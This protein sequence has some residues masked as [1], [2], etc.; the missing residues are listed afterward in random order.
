MT[1]YRRVERWLE[2]GSG[3]R[4]G[5]R[6]RRVSTFAAALGL[7]P[8]PL[9]RAVAV[10]LVRGLAAAAQK[11]TLRAVDGASRAAAQLE[12]AGDLQWPVDN[13]VYDDWSIALLQRL[14]RLRRR[15]AGSGESGCGMAAVA[16]RFVVRCTASA[17]SG[18]HRAHACDLQIRS[19]GER[20]VLAH[21]L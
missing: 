6:P 13:W 3:V 21:A 1:L 14:G 11:T 12:I 8:D 10:R 15:L 17:Q 4:I 9:V 2:C 5:A 7:E 20:S 16:V 19:E 18:A